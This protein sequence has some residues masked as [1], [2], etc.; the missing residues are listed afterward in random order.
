[1]LIIRLFIVYLAINQCFSLISCSQSQLQKY[2]GKIKSFY[3]S[4]YFL[5]KGGVLGLCGLTLFF[6]VKQRKKNRLY[7]QKKGLKD[8]LRGISSLGESD[9]ELSYKVVINNDSV[10]ERNSINHSDKNIQEQTLKADEDDICDGFLNEIR[11]DGFIK[12]RLNTILQYYFTVP[13]VEYDTRHDDLFTECIKKY[14]KA[15]EEETFLTQQ[16]FDIL[17]MLYQ[18]KIMQVSLLLSH[19][20]KNNEILFI[21]YLTYEKNN[22]GFNKSVL[23]NKNILQLSIEIFNALNDANNPIIK[24]INSNDLEQIKTL[25]QS[26]QANY[27]CVFYD[28]YELIKTTVE[29]ESFF[30]YKDVFKEEYENFIK[31]FNEFYAQISEISNNIEPTKL[32]RKYL[33]EHYALDR[34]ELS[35][36]Y[37]AKQIAYMLYHFSLDEIKTWC[38]NDAKNP[39]IF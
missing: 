12:E 28:L 14:E 8:F 35:F 18:G 27:S 5:K 4:M 7:V 11:Q 23:L 20:E 38:M 19:L 2:I 32:A 1:M 9:E 30:A 33:K 10:N 15:G 21:K 24:I 37:S 22:I 17:S 25:L 36:D 16:P 13:S 34:Y 3:A 39:S 31:R 26:W 29:R 6:Y